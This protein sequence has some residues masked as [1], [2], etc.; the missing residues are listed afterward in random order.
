MGGRAAYAELEELVVD[1]VFG[2]GRV[3]GEVVQ[4][5]QG[6]CGTGE[7]GQGGPCERLAV[8]PQARAERDRRFLGLDPVLLQLFPLLHACP[9]T[10]ESER[11]GIVWA[12]DARTKSVFVYNSSAVLSP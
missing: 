3:E 7:D 4:L 5:L 1:V 8:A 2:V 11:S 9:R 10:S 6:E 12:F